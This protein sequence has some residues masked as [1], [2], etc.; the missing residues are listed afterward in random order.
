MQHRDEFREKHQRQRQQRRA[1]H[2][3][4]RGGTS[5]TALLPS[6]RQAAGRLGPPISQPTE[7]N[8]AEIEADWSAEDFVEAGAAHVQDVQQRKTVEDELQE[9]AG[10][11]EQAGEEGLEQGVGKGVGG[12]TGRGGHSYDTGAPRSIGSFGHSEMCGFRS[13]ISF[14]RNLN[15]IRMELSGILVQRSLHFLWVLN[16]VG[17]WWRFLCWSVCHCPDHGDDAAGLHWEIKDDNRR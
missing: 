12:I 4:L 5:S 9:T 6:P 3:T 16:G 14:V 13:L 8:R 2:A 17:M 11:G 15:N 7:G 1:A 10:G